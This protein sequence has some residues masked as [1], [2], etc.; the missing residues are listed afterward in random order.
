MSAKTTMEKSIDPDTN[1]SSPILSVAMLR[2]IV[3]TML[4]LSVLPTSPRNKSVE[5]VLDIDSKNHTSVFGFM[6]K[7]LAKLCR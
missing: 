7:I 4:I 2:Q 3:P 6:E 5:H 1:D